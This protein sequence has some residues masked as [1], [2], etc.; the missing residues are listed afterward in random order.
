MAKVA[1][2]LAGTRNRPAEAGFALPFTSHTWYTRSLPA[3]G[4]PV[5]FRRPSSP[6]TA[7]DARALGAEASVTLALTVR[8]LSPPL[9]SSTPARTPTARTAVASPAA[10]SRRSDGSRRFHQGVR[11]GRAGARSVSSARAPA[12]LSSSASARTTA[13]MRSFSSVGGAIWSVAS[14]RLSAAPCSSSISRWQSAHSLRC[15]AKRSYSSS[16][17][18][19]RT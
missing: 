15:D 14:G 13:M 5:T 8:V 1:L 17:S 9:V 6:V 7:S 2:P 4:K 12:A 11:S 19:C 18:A 3:A 16:G 10:G